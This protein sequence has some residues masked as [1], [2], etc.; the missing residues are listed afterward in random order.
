MCLS[1]LGDLDADAGAFIGVLAVGAAAVGDGDVPRVA[2]AVE[3]RGRGIVDGFGDAAFPLDDEVRDLAV[4]VGVVCGHDAFLL[5]VHCVTCAC[6]VSREDGVGFVVC[7]YAASA[8]VAGARPEDVGVDVRG[9][10]DVVDVPR[11]AAV[12]LANIYILVWEILKYSTIINDD[13]LYF[14]LDYYR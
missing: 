8:A 10:V 6:C 14:F 2:G 13:F 7:P 5:E 11:P 3:D 9:V 12:G 4:D 1:G